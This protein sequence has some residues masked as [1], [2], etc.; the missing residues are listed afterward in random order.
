ML[1]LGDE[2]EQLTLFGAGQGRGHHLT[3]ARVERWEQLVDDR[4]G[5]GSDVHEKLAAIVRVTQTAD[6][7]SLLQVVEQ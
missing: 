6:Q 7:A 3:F 1:Q 5:S 2:S 4:L